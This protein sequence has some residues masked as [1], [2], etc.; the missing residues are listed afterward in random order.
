MSLSAFR[1]QFFY[2]NNDSADAVAAA[3]ACSYFNT[4]A[5]FHGFFAAAPLCQ[6]N[7][8][9]TKEHRVSVAYMII[10]YYR[11]I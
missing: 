3:D 5:V 4:V 10:N 9:L 7:V 8:Y 1:F 11:L 2:N 6:C